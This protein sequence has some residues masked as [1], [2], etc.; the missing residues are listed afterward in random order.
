MDIIC[1]AIFIVGGMILGGSWVYEAYKVAFK[2][3]L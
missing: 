3:E 1:A 2:E